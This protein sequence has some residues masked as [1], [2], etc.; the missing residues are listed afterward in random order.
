MSGSAGLGS[1]I[2][3]SVC[4]ANY[5]GEYLLDECISSIKN[6]DFP[7]PVEII[8]HDDASTD[9]SLE[10]LAERY[11]DAVVIASSKNVGYCLS[12]NRMAE[13]ARG[14]YL[15]LFN[16]DATLR[17]GALSALF[18]AAEKASVPVALSLPQYDHVTLALVDRGVR[19]DLFHT[20]FANAEEHC[21]TLAYVQAACMIIAR[22]IWNGLGGF[23]NWMQ[24]NAEDAYL[25]TLIRLAGG[26]ISVIE[27]SGYDHRQGQSFGGNRMSGE[28]ISTTYRRRYLSERN[29]ASMVLVCTPTFVAWLAYIF[30]LSLLV[31]EGVLVSSVK[32]EFAVFKRIYLPAVVDSLA[33]LSELV[34]ARA[35]V[36]KMRRIGI[37]KYIRI[38]SPVPHKLRVLI[39]HG[40]PSIR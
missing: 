8:V 5:N 10:V 15:L 18:F 7:F 38:F 37:W 39:R 3:I 31:I 33:R 21:E 20:P 17:E 9:A 29:R 23:P 13:R 22:D 14:K 11:P 6:Q 12:N 32:F 26:R 34:R 4:I 28:K 16:N 19:L 36:Q 24:S 35:H 25:C 30:H 1:E 27:G 2:A 40:L